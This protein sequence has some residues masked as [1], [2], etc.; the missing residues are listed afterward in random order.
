MNFCGLRAVLDQN[1]GG[2]FDFASL[3]LWSDAPTALMSQ[4]RFGG[5]G[6]L[7]FCICNRFVSPARYK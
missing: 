6:C 1:A 3:L 5:I 2:L 7:V 4:V